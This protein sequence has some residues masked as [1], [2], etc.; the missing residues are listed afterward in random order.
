MNKKQNHMHWAWILMVLFLVLGILDTRFGILGFLCMLAPM[1]HALLGR[2]KVHCRAYC[3]RG[4]LLGKW[5]P[6]FSLQRDMPTFMLHKWF[7]LSLLAVMV[8]VF[9]IS[10]AHANWEFHKIAFRVFRF[11]AMSLG[12]GIVLGI[13]YKPRSWCVVCP[14]GT[15]TGMIAANIR[16]TKS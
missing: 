6:S 14:M 1:T 4:S 9:S 7:K 8:C 15:A 16:Q 3:P 10:L 12:V 11:M 2:G 13:L 5:L